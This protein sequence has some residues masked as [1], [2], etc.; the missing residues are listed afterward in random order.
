ML[1]SLLI[2][3]NALSL[4]NCFY[5]IVVQNL[6]IPIVSYCRKGT[7]MEVD[8][9]IHSVSLV[10]CHLRAIRDFSPFNEYFIGE[11]LALFGQSG[12]GTQIYIWN[13]EKWGSNYCLE[14]MGS[15]EEIGSSNCGENDILILSRRIRSR[16]GQVSQKVHNTLCQ[17]FICKLLFRILSLLLPVCHWN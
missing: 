15:K 10:D 5:F 7:L 2:I 3:F 8:T 12:T 11:K 14:W 4:V 6:E 9:N 1:I 13:L 16:P 17:F